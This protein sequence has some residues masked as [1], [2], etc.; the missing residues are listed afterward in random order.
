MGVAAPVALLGGEPARLHRSR[1]SH[2]ARCWTSS[3]SRLRRTRRWGTATVVPV[4]AL[5]LVAAVESFHGVLLLAWSGAFLYGLLDGH[6]RNFRKGRNSSG[7]PSQSYS[8]ASRRIAHVTA[9][10]PAETCA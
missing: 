4:G 6:A 10:P 5:R 7:A 9:S 1:A 2:P 3:I 8:P